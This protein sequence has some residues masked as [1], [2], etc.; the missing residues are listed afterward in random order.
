MGVSTNGEIS[1][2]FMFD[3]GFE[4]PW[5]SEKWDG[6]VTEWWRG[7][8]GYVNPEFDP[9]DADGNHKPGVSE[10]D[11]R[12]SAYYA[13]S[14]EWDNAHP[15]PVELVNYCS[16]DCPMYILSISEVGAMAR[17]GY[18]EKLDFAK[19]VVSKEQ[20]DALKKFCADHSI[21]V[22]GEPSWWLSSYWG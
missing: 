10:N 22:E 15:V 19:F 5:D 14:R 1:F 9:Y 16:G 20:V 6:D 12:I 18:P 3:E 17:R 7:V 21:E 8:N 11:P 4:F 13:H 2:G